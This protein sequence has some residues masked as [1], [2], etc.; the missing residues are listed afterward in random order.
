MESLGRA[1][2]MPWSLIRLQNI[3]NGIL[4]L[5]CSNPK[6]VA[7]ASSAGQ[8]R[9]E[10]LSLGISG[11]S[12]REDVKE[13]EV[14]WDDGYGTV[15][16]KDY[17]DG[18]REM[19]RPDG[20]PPRWFC[21]IECRQPL[22]N[23]PVLLFLPGIDGLGLGLILHHKALGKVF[24]VRCL[25]IP[26]HD[27]TPFEGLVKFVEE[28]IRLEHASS[29]DKPIY[30]VGDSF[31]GCVAL[32]VAA[33]NS[34]IDLV[35]ILVNP[36]TSFGRSLLQPL[37][38]IFKAVP[39]EIYATI[40]CLL[41][42]GIG[43]P[44]KIPIANL[45]NTFPEKKKLE[46][47]FDNLTALLPHLSE[48]ANIIPKESLSWKFGLLK[49]AVGFANSCLHAVKAE[50]LLLLSGK[51]NVLFSR[52][53]ALQLSSS[54]PNCKVRYFKNNGCALLLENGFNLLS[55][56]K[57]THKYR[58]SRRHDFVLD[59]LPPSMSE[60]EG[61]F[62]EVYRLLRL[63]TSPVMFSTL[64]DGKI[65]RSLAGVP[66]E[67]PVL[68]VGCHMLLG[69]EVGFLIEEFLK[70]K[71]VM[72][73]GLAHPEVL[74]Q[75]FISASNE[76]SVLDYFS[77][78][79]ALPVTAR[80]FF[81]LLS[82]DS[83]VLLY[84]GGMREALHRK[85]ENHKLFW[86]EQGEFVRMAARFG[87]SIVPFGAVGADDIMELV[88]DYNE[89][90]QIPL[91]SDYTRQINSK[92]INLRDQSDGEVANQGFCAP[93]FLPKFPGRFYFLFGKPIET[94][95]KEKMLQDRKNA[96]ELYLRVKS[97]VERNIAY[98]IEKRKE[99]PRR[100]FISR[101]MHNVFSAPVHQVPTFEP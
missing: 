76:F 48:F 4:N 64:S 44:T 10:K 39:D 9:N 24:E 74:N 28:T 62:D 70:E 36:A 14:L 12:N 59:F 45:N 47:L 3:N 56:I 72:V 84:P 63:S 40:P 93:V 83:Y 92:M 85:G 81:K 86:P 69:I 37:L 6:M 100:N 88:L 95:G 26:I 89:M 66:N 58:H 55:V 79:G 11:K 51:D 33:R 18:A 54:L 96:Q 2:C 25:H 75:P 91:L 43:D 31:G 67:G 98:L 34:T 73:R 87:A 53:E 82:T 77:I 30:L 42:F 52:D 20:G 13:L 8:R 1:L 35:L 5:F 65:V 32:S 17:L 101:L 19:I 29:P 46:Q 57:G 60:F 90:L 94:K 78:F 41:N 68:L 15:G 97:E 80:N 49:S 99:D 23:S 27:R 16:L 71:Q 38:P 61:K 22:K 21:P 7:G 50:V